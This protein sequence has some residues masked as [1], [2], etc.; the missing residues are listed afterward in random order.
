MGTKILDWIETCPWWVAVA[1]GAGLG[2]LA[3]LL[4]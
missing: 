4:S 2:V 1:L 3:A